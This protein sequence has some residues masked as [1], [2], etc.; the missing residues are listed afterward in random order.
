[1]DDS[2]IIFEKNKSKTFLLYGKKGLPILNS[3]CSEIKMRT[4]EWRSL[5][6]LP[7]DEAAQEAIILSV[8][9]D[10]GG[11]ANNL[12]ELDKISIK[13]AEFA[14]KL[15]D[16]ESYARTLS[17]DVW[18]KKR[19]AFLDIF[20]RY[21]LVL[22]TFFD[23]FNYLPR[24]LMLAVH[25]CDFS[26]VHQILEALSNIIF[27]LEECKINIKAAPSGT[28]K[29]IIAIFKSD[30]KKIIEE[31]IEAAFPLK[32]AKKSAKLWKCYFNKAHDLYSHL[33]FR[34]IQ[35]TH[36]DYIE[37]DLSFHPLKRMLL[38][39]LF[40]TFEH[41]LRKRGFINSHDNTHRRQYL[42]KEVYEGCLVVSK[43]MGVQTPNNV[44]LGV[45]FP[46]R[47]LNIHELYLIHPSPFSLKGT[48]SIKKCMLALRGFS[49][50]NL[51]SCREDNMMNDLIEI[52]SAKSAR[53]TAHIAVT[54]WKTDR[55]SWIASVCSKP[56]PDNLRLDRLNQLLNS[57]L[58]CR[59]K[60]DYLVLPELSV[61]AH[62][63]LAI[64]GK[65]RSNGIS[66]I[67]GI[68]YFHK[69]K[70]KVLHNQV[71]AALEC[72][73]FG[74]P[75]TVIYRQDKQNPALHEE[76]DIFDIAGKIL[77]PQ[78]RR[79]STPPII[80]HGNFHFTILI[81]SEFSNISY[82]ASLQGKVDALFL[83]EWNQDTDSFNTLVESAARDI[84]AYIIQCNDRQYGDSRIRAPYKENWM[85]DVVRVKGGVEDYFVIGK[86]NIKELRNFQSHYRSPDSLFKP[87]PDGFEISYD[88]KILPSINI[89]K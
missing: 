36:A 41:S 12:R 45:L 16:V 46:T 64:V 6:N 32:L 79:W 21:V 25:C 10:D 38:P 89:H 31:A 4:S 5:P 30:L 84:H 80:V 73:A 57:V 88:R 50:D 14:L 59:I 85:R 3:I 28:N 74:F 1:M 81:C 9:R 44:P 37:H 34:V 22:P 29:N 2:E 19:Q 87:V 23:F 26:Y 82:R 33:D 68:E 40:S 49:P 48:E 63:F 56:D 20:I 54:S 69:R 76:K 77:K 8:L 62:W 83:P 42:E 17:P 51:P 39:S 24:V 66:L 13:R 7:N 60:P 52:P 78:F 43:F 18:E 58:H 75:A 67:C 61:P 55:E 35:T 15:R 27:Q 72:D 71:W 86:I 70:K 53:D 11:T 65:L 47:P